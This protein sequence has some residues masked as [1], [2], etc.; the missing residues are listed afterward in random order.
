[1]AQAN[2]NIVIN[3]IPILVITPEEEAQIN[4][5]HQRTAKLR[6]IACGM[7]RYDREIDVPY[8]KLGCLKMDI[9]S[10]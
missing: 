1:M 9:Y 4:K 8:L 10:K 5:N 7:D 3:P 6:E 2:S